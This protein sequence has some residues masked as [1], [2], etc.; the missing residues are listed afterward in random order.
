MS[1]TNGTG[2]RY[3]LFLSGCPFH[4]EGCHSP[5]TQ[6]YKYGDK[7][8]I[9]DIFYNIIKNKNYIDGVTISGGEPTEQAD[10]LKKL[11]K[12]LKVYDINIWMWSGHTMDTLKEKYPDI[13]HNIDTVIDGQYEHTNPTSKVYRGSDNQNMWKKENGEWKKID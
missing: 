7:E 12:L 4:C 9:I 3:T 13:L 1:N 5:H 11:L 6:D 10:G 8:K 2:L